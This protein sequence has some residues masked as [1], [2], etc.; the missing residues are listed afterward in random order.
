MK[1]DAYLPVWV[2]ELPAAF[3]FCP[4]GQVRDHIAYYCSIG[5]VQRIFAGPD[6]CHM[7]V[8]VKRLYHKTVSSPVHP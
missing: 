7:L 3:V 6:A 1:A 4:D 8:Y 5:V 2:E